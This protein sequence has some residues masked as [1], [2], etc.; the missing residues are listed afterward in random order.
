MP[1]IKVKVSASNQNWLSYAGKGTTM[2]NSFVRKAFYLP[3]PKNANDKEWQEWVE[4]D[5]QR[6]RIEKARFTRAFNKRNPPSIDS[7][8]EMGVAKVNG[9]YKQVVAVGFSGNGTTQIEPIVEA[10]QEL[11]V[12]SFR[13]D[14]THKSAGTRKGRKSARRANRRLAKKSK[15]R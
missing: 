6:A 4:K 1:T 3:P 15:Y 9:T 5:E 14:K 10:Q 8:P 12:D 2:D 13:Q 7:L 11:L